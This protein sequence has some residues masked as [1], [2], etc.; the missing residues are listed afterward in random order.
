MEGVAMN[1][2]FDQTE[3]SLA[4]DQFV[5][6]HDCK[7][8]RVQ[9][10]RGSLWVTQ[11]GDATDYVLGTGQVLELEHGGDAIVFALMQSEVTLKQPAHAPSPL[12]SFGNML[13]ALLDGMNTW[14]GARF[15]PQA[16]NS[17]KVRNLRGAM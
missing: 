4:P 16:I 8:S 13:L 5:T 15:G 10:N 11:D 9:C 14:I 7:G 17:R 2:K 3:V 1:R 6:L 12:D